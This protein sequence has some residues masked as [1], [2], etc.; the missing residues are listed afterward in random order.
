LSNLDNIGQIPKKKVK[1][2][3]L[4]GFFLSKNFF[5]KKFLPKAFKLSWESLIKLLPPFF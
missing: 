2:L 3:S 1:K 5:G 4:T